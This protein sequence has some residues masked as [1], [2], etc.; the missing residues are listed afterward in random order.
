MGDEFLFGGV[1]DDGAS[2]VFQGWIDAVNA[3]D[4]T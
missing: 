1:S 2:D 4:Y 3:Y